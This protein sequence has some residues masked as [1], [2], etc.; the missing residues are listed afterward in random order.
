MINSSDII[1]FNPISNFRD[2]VLKDN[3]NLFCEKSGCK[4]I[5][6]GKNTKQVLSDSSDYI[7]FIFMEDLLKNKGV[8]QTLLPVKDK[9]IRPFYFFLDK[10]IKLYA[11]LKKLKY[12]KIIKKNNKW[13]EF[14]NKL[15]KNHPEIK[16]ATVNSYLSLFN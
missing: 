11:D 9:I 5:N 16:Q 13:E 10:E 14:M 6:Q 2:V 12:N 15:E 8:P 4:V 1:L 3:L 7:S